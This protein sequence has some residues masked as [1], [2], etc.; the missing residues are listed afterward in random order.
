MVREVSLASRVCDV[1]RLLE[2]GLAA[3]PAELKQ[4]SLSAVPLGSLGK[5][6]GFILLWRQA[7]KPFTRGELEAMTSICGGMRTAIQ[8]RSKACEQ[9]AGTNTGR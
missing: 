5:S 1:H 9:P 3:N 7:E 2:M 6:T 4:L 8:S